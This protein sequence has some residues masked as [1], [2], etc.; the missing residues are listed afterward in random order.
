MYSLWE[1]VQQIGGLAVLGVFAKIIIDNLRATTFN[2]QWRA[3]RK[4]FDDAN[5][6]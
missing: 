1:T 2:P 6:D 5:R 3:A 4:A